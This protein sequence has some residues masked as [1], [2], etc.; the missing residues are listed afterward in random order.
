ME[1]PLSPLE[2]ALVLQRF[3]EERPPN[4]IGWKMLTL[5]Q[6]GFG[7]LEGAAKDQGVF[8]LSVYGDVNVA[9]EVFVAVG[10]SFVPSRW[11]VGT[12]RNDITPAETFT[13]FPIEGVADQCLL[14]AVQGARR[15]KTRVRL[16][17][18]VIELDLPA[19]CDWRG[20]VR[21]FSATLEVLRPL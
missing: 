16:G 7:Q 17:S 6:D 18:A 13:G 4:A 9:A 12:A 3:N 8:H 1:M 11:S 10:D 2:I 21:R 5:N 19:G 20:V 15:M 14:A